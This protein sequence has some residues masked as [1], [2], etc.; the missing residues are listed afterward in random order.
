[1]LAMLKEFK[2]FI[3]RGNV[4]DMAVGIIIGVAFGKIVSSLVADVI[5]PPIG[6]A[7]GSVD[8][9]SLFFSLK[10]NYPTVAAAKAASAPTINYGLF[11]NSI[12]EFLIVAFAVFL[13][14]K[15]INNLRR[16]PEDKPA[17]TTE[18]PFCC[19]KIPTKAMR[20][21]A[22]TSELKQAAL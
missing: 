8:F 19:T 20:C 22:C 18:C 17:D 4:I 16:K 7:L 13:L 5:M 12:I 9:S 2:E 11:I 6:L 14:L 3:A 10:G 15:A 1:M 21:P